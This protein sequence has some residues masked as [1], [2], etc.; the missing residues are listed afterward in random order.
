VHISRLP[1]GEPSPE[2]I[3][4]LQELSNARRS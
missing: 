4:R 1:A 3:R 2:F